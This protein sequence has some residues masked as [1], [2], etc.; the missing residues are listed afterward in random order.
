MKLTKFNRKDCLDARGLVIVID[1]IRAFTTS[2]YAFASGA[3][4]IILVSSVDEAFR[5]REKNPHYLLMGEVNGYM[6]E[7]FDFGNSPRQFQ[8]ADLTGRTLVQRTSSGTQ[9][10]VAAV[11]AGHILTGS[12]VIAQAT[13][14]RIRNL[15]PEQVSFI[16]TGQHDGSEDLAFAE[17]LEACLLGHAPDPSHYLQKVK[18]SPGASRSLA[19]PHD[20]CCS[21]DDLHEVLR[22]DH[23]AFATEVLREREGLTMRP[24]WATGERWRHT[25]QP[26]WR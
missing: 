21:Q 4:R 24:V 8:G 14:D 26:T 19:N 5:L 2:A 12:F 20:H 25:D 11:N 10:V 18:D 1:V 23:Y 9:G 3:E 6:V 16:I 22:L 15:K 7:G 13:L 17:Y